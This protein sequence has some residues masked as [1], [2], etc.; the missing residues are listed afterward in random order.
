MDHLGILSSG[1]F[2][3]RRGSLT[4]SPPAV[5]NLSVDGGC[6][7]FCLGLKECSAP[8]RHLTSLWRKGILCVLGCPVLGVPLSFASPVKSRLGPR[9][10]SSHHRSSDVLGIQAPGGGPLGKGCWLMVVG[11]S[12]E[13]HGLA[14]HVCRRVG[15]GQSSALRVSS[16]PAGWAMGSSPISDSLEILFER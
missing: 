14:R 7:L 5:T 1:A 16:F 4:R 6:V 3:I 11:E 10:L 12:Q 13:L 8:Q 2:E 9:G 15:A